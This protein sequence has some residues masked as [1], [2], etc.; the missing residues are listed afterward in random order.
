MRPALPFRLALHLMAQKVRLLDIAERLGITKVSVS[1]ALRDHGD[2]SADT[3]ALVKK[4]AAEMGYTPNLLA[5]SL[6]SQRS[7]TLGVV[8]PKIAHTF[9][10]SVIDAVQN[11]ATQRGYGVVLAVSGE[12]SALEC[13]H[14]E[15]LLAMRVDGLLVSVSEEA[16]DL[17][18]YAHVRRMGVPLVFF[19]R[20]IRGLGF[21]SVT[22]DDRSAAR[23]AV[24]H[25]IEEGYREIVHVAGTDA[26]EIGHERRAGYEE[27]LRAHG[28]EVRDDLVLPGGF[29]E[30][31]GYHAMSDLLARGASFDAVFS[32]TLPVAIGVHGALQA[33]APERLEGT[34][35]VSFGEGSLNEFASVSDA[36]LRQ[37]TR[38]MGERAVAMLLGE[39]KGAAAADTHIVLDVELAVRGKKGA[40]V[41]EAR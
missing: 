4:T 37:P 40:F 13:Q 33:H 11:V 39:I 28:I 12:N 5:R 17:E 21:S 24:S 34:Y 7:H 35:L 6:S 27:A 36:T 31:H 32:A 22:V 23:R 10:S 9:F 2:I 25:I 15:R 16:P 14:I 38:E 30:W 29:D 20:Q 18:I 8:V 3:R 1:K 41:P 26:V 19:D